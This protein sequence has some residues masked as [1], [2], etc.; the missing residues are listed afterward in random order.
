MSGSLEFVGFIKEGQFAPVVRDQVANG[1][2]QFEGK[3]VA[4]TIKEVKRR[5]S[6]SQNAFYFGFVV[7]PIVAML[8]SYGNDVGNDEVHD[9]LKQEVGKLN[10][11][12]VLPDGE[13][14]RVTGSTTTLTTG[15]FSDY[16]E[17]CLA[18]AA[19]HGLEIK[20]PTDV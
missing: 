19:E 12:I 14:K 11:V 17:K 8:R 4:V 13:V 5:R 1:L 15:E 20:L 7:P 2:K 9:Y 16:I 10:R 3:R 6:N 18:F